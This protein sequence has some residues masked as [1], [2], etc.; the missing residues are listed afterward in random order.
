MSDELEFQID[1]DD[2]RLESLY[3]DGA[4]QNGGRGRTRPISR[5]ILDLEDNDEEGG[6]S[7]ESADNGGRAHPLKRGST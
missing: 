2:N 1:E 3:F 4:I 7:R 6:G 5:G